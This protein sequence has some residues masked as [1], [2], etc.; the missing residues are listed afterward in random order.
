MDDF[1]NKYRS[2][3]WKKQGKNWAECSVCGFQWYYS[4][5]ANKSDLKCMERG[6]NKIEYEKNIVDAFGSFIRWL[7]K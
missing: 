7:E 2:S 3:N 4:S 5:A 6:S 1:G